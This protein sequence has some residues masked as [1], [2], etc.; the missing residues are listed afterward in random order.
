[1]QHVQKTRTTTKQKQKEK[2]MAGPVMVMRPTHVCAR[3]DVNP[4][5]NRIATTTKVYTRTRA[6][7]A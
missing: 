1:M 2:E 4:E 3:I 5:H 7:P 6:R